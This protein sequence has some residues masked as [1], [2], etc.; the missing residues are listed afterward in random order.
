M[1]CRLLRLAWSILAVT[2]VACAPADSTGPAES[3]SDPDGDAAAGGDVDPPPDESDAAQDA[4]AEHPGGHGA[5]DTCTGALVYHLTADAPSANAVV[6]TN[7]LEPDYAL[8]CG[9]GTGADAAFVVRVDAPSMLELVVQQATTPIPLHVEVRAG[10]CAALDGGAV[11]GC[12]GDA[13]NSPEAV[14]FRV[15]GDITV[16]VKA[17]DLGHEA[18]VL[19]GMRAYPIDARPTDVWLPAEH[20]EALAFGPA[21]PDLT[22]LAVS[23]RVWG[24]RQFVL[25]GG[26]WRPGPLWPDEWGVQVAVSARGAVAIAPPTFPFVQVYP[27]DPDRAWSVAVPGNTTGIA[28]DPAGDHLVTTSRTA[29]AE[30]LCRWSA[31]P[32]DPDRPW[33]AEAVPDWSVVLDLEGARERMVVTDD[34]IVRA[35]AS[36]E[37][38]ALADGAVLGPP[39]ALDGT[40]GGVSPDGR[41]LVLGD[42]LRLTDDQGETVHRLDRVGPLTTV[43]PAFGGG[44]VAVTLG[45]GRVG[46]YDV[47]TGDRVLHRQL[48]AEPIR[49]IAMDDDGRRLAV[50]GG[51]DVLVVEI[52]P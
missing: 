1:K 38:H 49:A 45:G 41:H 21:G 52:D 48:L 42:P 33:G 34:A 9:Q 46:V 15:D 13:D 39:I 30:T 23:G 16:I 35:A 50:S 22:G 3:H 17:D 4:D 19:L 44:R 32:V 14:R 18:P 8:S 43:L 51:V 31:P 37:R 5:V 25:D 27:L 20:V 6:Y 12:F 10:D 7:V 36:V 29:D 24:T 11:R 2:A 40:A 28:W 26:A 47:E